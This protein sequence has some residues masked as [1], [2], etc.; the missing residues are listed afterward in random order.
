MRKSCSFC[1]PDHVGHFS[2]EK[3]LSYQLNGVPEPSTESWYINEEEELNITI[4]NNIMEILQEKKRATCN[5]DAR[6]VIRLNL[7]DNRVITY[8]FTNKISG[9]LLY[10]W[11]HKGYSNDYAH[12]I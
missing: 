5:D 2:V 1:V 12:T 4:E 8:N 9:K 3:T 11:L 10:I 7:T 6:F